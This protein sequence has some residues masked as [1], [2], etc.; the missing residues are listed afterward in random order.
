[1][2]GEYPN[3]RQ[4]ARGFT[5]RANGLGVVSATNTPQRIVYGVI[6]HIALGDVGTYDSATGIFTCGRAGVFLVKA[7]WHGPGASNTSRFD[8]A[9]YRN[10]AHS[11]LL[12]RRVSGGNNSVLLSGVVRMVLAIGDTV[13]VRGL[14]T[15]GDGTVLVG[16][17][18]FLAWLGE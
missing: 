8:L 10:G 13:E 3:P 1:L 9:I 5:A 6:D 11:R 16:S 12:D 18:F 15:G 2:T 4:L 14:K 7:S 17:E